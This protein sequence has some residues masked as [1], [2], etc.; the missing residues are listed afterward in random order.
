MRIAACKITF[1][2][3]ISKDA[4]YIGRLSDVHPWVDNIA[5]HKAIKEALPKQSLETVGKGP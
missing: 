2:I 3:Y 5:I 1:C 4:E